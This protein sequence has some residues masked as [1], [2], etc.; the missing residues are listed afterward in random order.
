MRPAAGADKEAVALRIVPGVHG[1]LSHPHQAAV[2]VLAHSGRYALGHDA[3]PGAPAQVNH[4]GAGIGLLMVVGDGHRIK[5][6]GG[7][8]PFQDGGWVFPGNGAAGFHLG[9]AKVAAAPL[10]DA[11][12]GHE[13][14]DTALA[15]RISGIP[16]LDGGVLDIGILFHDDFHHGG[17]QLLFVPHGGGAAFHVTHVGAFIGHDERALELA[18]AF[19]IDAEVAAELHRAAD[20]LGDI[21]EG[22]VGENGAVEGGEIVV[23]GRHHRR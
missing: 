22:T 17:V 21:A 16:V 5:L 7:K 4:L 13:V 6:R 11:A 12:L 3:A 1:I 8:I 2:A 10:A 9:P 19:C 23:A 14:Q 15:I 20:A 18:G